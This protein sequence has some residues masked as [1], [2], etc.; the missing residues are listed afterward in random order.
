MTVMLL[1]GC[2]FENKKTLKVLTVAAHPPYSF[3]QNGT[4]VGFD[5]DVIKFIGDKL[6]Y[7]LEI[8]DFDL[9]EL[10]QALVAE[11]ADV[12]IASIVPTPE[13]RKIMDFSTQYSGMVKYATLYNL[14]ESFS[15]LE[16]MKGKKIGAIK[17]AVSDEFLAAHKGE[18]NWEITLYN[19]LASAINALKAYKIDMFLVRSPA[20]KN[21][22][23]QYNLNYSIIDTKD[24]SLVFAIAFPKGSALTKEFNEV[25]I[26][27]RVLGKLDVLKDKW[28]IEYD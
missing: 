24:T 10:L 3:V 14:G 28:G 2:D 22:A 9:P 7:K 13:K 12:A 26:E 25:I 8:Q 21:H 5:I 4:L 11:K 6:N 20:A 18:Y 23:E 19:D 17:E 15:T 16:S 27:M 1:C